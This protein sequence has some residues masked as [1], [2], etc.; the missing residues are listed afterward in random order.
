NDGT[1]RVWAGDS[2]LPGDIFAPGV[3]VLDAQFTGDGAQVRLALADDTVRLWRPDLD[4]RQDPATLQARLRAATT[5]CLRP[6]DRELL[7]LEDAELARTTHA[8]CEARHAR[9]PDPDE[10]VMRSPPAPATPT[11][12]TPPQPT[13]SSASPAGRSPSNAG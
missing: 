11:T 13:S 4:A 12:T 7:L 2:G 1:A 6:R 8:A 5:S 9:T 10:G 3:A